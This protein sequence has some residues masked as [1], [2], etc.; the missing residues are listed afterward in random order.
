M[1]AVP[2]MVSSLLR[3]RPGLEGARACWQGG[4]K[5]SLGQ[6]GGYWRRRRAERAA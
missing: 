5:A 6:V 4:C 2:G 3:K 1:E